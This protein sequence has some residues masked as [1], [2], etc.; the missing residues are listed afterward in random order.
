MSVLI[1]TSVGNLT[2]DL[3]LNEAASTCENFLKLC[4]VKYY[5]GNLFWSVQA[6]FTAQTGDPTGTGSGG[7]SI[8]RHINQAK[9]DTALNANKTFCDEP[10]SKRQLNQ[11]GL[12]CMSHSE[13]AMEANCSQFFITLRNDGFEHLHGKH[14]VLG[15]VAE[16][17]DTLK[18]INELYCDEN[19]RPYQDVRI[20][21]TDILYDPFIDPIGLE[22]VL[23]LSS[24]KSSKNHPFIPREEKLRVRLPYGYIREEDNS[25]SQDKIVK[26]K[27]A[28]A[29]AVVLEMLGDLPDADTKPPDEVLF[30]CKLNAITKDEDLELIFSRFGRVKDCS[31]LRDRI[32]GASLQYAFVEFENEKSCLRA[33]EK[34]NNVLVDDR[35]IKVDFSQSVSNIWNQFRKGG[36][37]KAPMVDQKPNHTV[38]SSTDRGQQL[39]KHHNNYHLDT[40]ADRVFRRSRSRSRD[41]DRNDHGGESGRY[42]SRDYRGDPDNRAREWDTRGGHVDGRNRGNERERDMRRS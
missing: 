2:I 21:H 22:A 17:A 34:M 15:E 11:V 41:R 33:Y 6:N 35:R 16:G 28:A 32:T 4:K 12:L 10:S 3:F 5:H 26:R 19:D 20:L 18:A 40:Q 31:I 29:T 13:G 24:P 27:D 1:A 25:V 9:Q 7:S 38:V 37:S 8:W 42:Q 39:P 30:V 36:N 14:T 23:P